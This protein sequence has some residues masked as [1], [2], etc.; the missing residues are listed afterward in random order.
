MSEKEKLDLHTPEAVFIGLRLGWLTGLDIIQWA[1][2]ALAEQTPWSGEG[3]LLEIASLN[4][5]A[6]DAPEKAV[7]LL[8][9]RMADCRPGFDEDSPLARSLV[10]AWVFSALKAYLGGYRPARDLGD[11][12]GAAEQVL[13]YPAWCGELWQACDSAAHLNRPEDQARLRK[14]AKRILE[15]EIV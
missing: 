4:Q 8:S 10:R 12:I 5:A 15:E 13:N 11:L 14:T 2:T 9:A 7:R 1:E 6:P 3:G